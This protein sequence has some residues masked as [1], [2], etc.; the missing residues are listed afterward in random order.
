MDAACHFTAIVQGAGLTQ[1]EIPEEQWPIA[2]SEKWYRIVV[3]PDPM[4]IDAGEEVKL[5]VTY[6]A[7]GFETIVYMLI[8]GSYQEYYWPYDG[9]SQEDANYVIITMVN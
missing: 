4:K 9:T 3:T 7:T 5:A 2:A 1:E 6:K 8:N